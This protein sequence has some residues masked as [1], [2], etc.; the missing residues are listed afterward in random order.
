MMELFTY[1]G[2][3]ESIGNTLVNIVVMVLV[4]NGRDFHIECRYATPRIKHAI[5]IKELEDERVP[6]TT[7]LNFLRDNGIKKLTAIIDSELRNEI[8][9]LRFDFRKNRVVIKGKPASEIASAGTVRLIYGCMITLISIA[10]A[11]GITLVR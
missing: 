11:V 4:A 8:A 9:H 3:V 2:L 1:M 5:S 6:L 10:E 7:K